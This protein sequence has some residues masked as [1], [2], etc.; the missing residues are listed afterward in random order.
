MKIGNKILSIMKVGKRFVGHEDWKKKGSSTMK[1]GNK[2][3]VDHEGRKK[4]H[5]P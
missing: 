1:V 2:E 4:V 3:I 5:Q